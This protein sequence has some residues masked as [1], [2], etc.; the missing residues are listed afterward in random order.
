M[1]TSVI[2]TVLNEQKTIFSLLKSLARQNK[3]PNEVIIVDGGSKDR[4]TELI[5]KF[6]LPCKL[7]LLEKKGNRAIGRNE[8]IRKAEYEIIAIT[9]A[10]C[11]LDKHWLKEITDPFNDYDVEVVSGYY[12]IRANSV[13]EKCVGVY[14]LVMPKSIRSQEFLPS[15]R[16]MA[17][18]KNVWKEVG[19]FPEQSSLNEDYV[20]ARRLKKLH[21]KICFA[22]NAIVYWA[23]RNNIKDAFSM[24]YQFAR[25]DAR[26]FLVRP[27]VIFIFIRYVLGIL[28]FI[29]ALKNHD[30]YIF[31][32]ILFLQYAGW[33]IFKNYTYV[34]RWEAIYILPMLQLLSDIAVILGT[35]HGFAESKYE[36]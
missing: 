7:T 34:K 10:G 20:F 29:L 16:S 22:K 32:V 15:S 4:T 31:V 1:K 21:K 30:I 35:I 8:G 6:K 3:K 33:S 5:K 2:I 24:F 28:L 13:F 11:I 18:R 25:G 9:D 14:S 23:P 26:A 12:K 17:L 36:K 19:E 27:K